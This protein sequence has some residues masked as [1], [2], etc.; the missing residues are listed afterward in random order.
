MTHV[1]ILLSSQL[2][3]LGKSTECQCSKTWSLGACQLAGEMRH[4]AVRP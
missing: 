1:L 3:L 4:E 2:F